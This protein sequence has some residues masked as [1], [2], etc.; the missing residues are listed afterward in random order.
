M[1]LIAI[2][3]IVVCLGVWIIVK[4]RRKRAEYELEQHSIEPEVLHALLTSQKDIVL[5]DVRLPLDLL[6]K[7][8]GAIRIPPKE[9]LANSSLIPREKDTVVYC[10]CPSDKTSKAVLRRALA[11]EFTNIK[12]LRRGLEG[13]KAKG[14]EVE[15]YRES[16]HLDTAV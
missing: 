14:F 2:T 10:T 9:I 6:E 13:W 1:T 4:M 3:A 8:P 11:L 15:P 16:F 5:L 12:F 7:I